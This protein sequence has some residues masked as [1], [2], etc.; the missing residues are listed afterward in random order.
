MQI[1]FDYFAQRLNYRFGSAM[2]KGHPLLGRCPHPQISSYTRTYRDTDPSVL[3][4]REFVLVCPYFVVDDLHG[5]ESKGGE[6]GNAW[7]SK[8]QELPSPKKE[9]G[10]KGFLSER[11]WYLYCFCTCSALYSKDKTTRHDITV[12]SF[13]ATSSGGQARCTRRCTRRPPCWWFGC[14]ACGPNSR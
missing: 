4:C 7:K 1:V 9:R 8:P 13:R 3:S 5:R 14:G 6:M 10:K 2:P 11:G 12:S